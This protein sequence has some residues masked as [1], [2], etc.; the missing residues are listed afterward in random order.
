M[1]I[2]ELM[3]QIELTNSLITIDAMGCK[4]ECAIGIVNGGGDFVLAVKDN[5]P[6]LAQAIKD[7]I[8]QHPKTALGYLNY[9]RYAN[10]EESNA[11]I[12]KRS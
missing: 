11:G 12:D 4:K 9:R 1:A 7:V 3:K 10:R 2:R 8:A 5:Q 6:K